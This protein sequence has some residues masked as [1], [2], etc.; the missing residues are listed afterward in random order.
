M[1]NI[2][3]HVIIELNTKDYVKLSE[4]DKTDKNE[5]IED[6]VVS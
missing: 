4:L 5:L 6:I 3:Y 2:F 1:T